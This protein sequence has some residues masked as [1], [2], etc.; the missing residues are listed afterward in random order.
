MTKK[1]L[2]SHD[3]GTS[4]DKATLFSIDGK[5]LGSQIASYDTHYFN[6]TWVEQDAGDWWKAF[7]RSTRALIA[8]AGIDPAEIGGISFSG[9][10]MGCLCVDRDGTPLRPAIIWADTRAQEEAAIVA[11][12]IDMRDYYRVVGHRISASYGLY[13]FMWVMRNEPEIYART[14]KTLNAKDFIVQRL[15]GTF[16]TDYSDADGVGFFDLH[17]LDWSPELLELSGLDRS[18]LP[19][20]KPST[21]VAGVVTKEAAAMAGLAEGT[22]VVIGA[23]DGV[24]SNVGAGSISPGNTFCCLGTS[25]WV[26][27]TSDKPLFD[28]EMRTVTWAH[29]VP[30]LYSPNG[31]MQYAGG[32]YSWLRNN[33]CLKEC[34]KAKT[35]GVSAFDLMN[36]EAAKSSPG[37]NGLIFLPYLLGERA[38]RWDSDIRGC[39]LGIKAET[40]R[41]DMI[42]SVMEGVTYNLALILDILRSQTDIREIVCLG[43]GAKGELWQ[44]IMADVFDARILVPDILEEA[45]SM[46][47]AVCA[48]VGTGIYEDFNAIN[49][50]FSV[51]AKREPDKSAQEAYARARADFDRFYFALKDAFKE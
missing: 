22:P 28:D 9:Q 30:G 44:Q 47:A 32:S 43:G 4:G 38:P 24:A 10:M 29:M 20:V 25:A 46:G 40:T 37:S 50:F 17:T 12:Q 6:D 23:G 31:T 49:R 2:L 35:G 42:R 34:D 21:F 26:A 45:G 27:S 3:L 33:V 16:C 11:A 19:D 36:E 39:F 5:M 13:K 41:G 14:Y 15:T 51:A 7:C 8:S 1:Y 18:K 48:G